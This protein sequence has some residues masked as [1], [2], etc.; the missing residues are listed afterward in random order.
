MSQMAKDDELDRTMARNFG[1]PD[2]AAARAE[3]IEPSSG[4]ATLVMERVRAEAASAAAPGP[5]AFPWRRAVPG[6][7]MA[8]LALMAGATMLVFGVMAVTRLAS[9]ALLSAAV[10][11]NAHATQ[12]GPAIW[13]ETASRLHVGWLLVALAIALL[14]LVA[15]RGLVGRG[16]RA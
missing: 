14:P 9:R 8:V 4:F 13:I 6:I 3:S 12:T 2:S 15:S 16:H 10:Q 1:P 5:I 11:E 7:C